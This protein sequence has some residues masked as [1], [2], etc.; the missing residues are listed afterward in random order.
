MLRLL[1]RVKIPTSCRRC[2]STKSTVMGFGDGSHGA[3]GLP[4]SIIGMGSD[5]YEPTPIPGLPPDVVSIAAGHFHSLAVTS[6][7]DVWSWGRNNEGQ[8][9]RHPLSLREAWNEPKRVEGLNKVRVQAAFASGVISAAVGDDGSLWVWG[10]S[11]H[12]QLGLGKGITHAALPSKIET[13]PGEEIVK[14]SLGWG[15]ALALAKNGSLFGWGYYADGRI[16]KIGRELEISPLESNSTKLRSGEEFS[17]IEA[18]EKSVMEAIEKE[19]D[20]PI[21][22]EPGSIE[23]LDELKVADVACGLDHSLVLCRDGTLLSGGSN[24]YGQL[25]RANKDLGMQPVDIELHPLSIA[26]GLGHS[27]A[28]CNDPSSEPTGDA[29]SVVSWGWNQSSQLGREGP[30]NIPNVVEGLAD[31]TPVSVS[32]GRAHSLAL[33]AKKEVWSW[34]SGRNGRL[35]LGSS[36]DEAE[37]MLVEY[38]EGTEVI[39]AVAGLDH[40]L[41]LV[42]E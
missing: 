1:H 7:G 32:A 8:L 34:G 29:T 36:A 15:H 3:L 38:L 30:D 2:M 5:A 11:K 28:V 16:G 23:E 21:I 39:Q 42:A 40:S 41:V 27:L 20:M 12:G 13:L 4:G 6:E 26:S 14:V 35:G 25:G 22:W 37:P 10:S 24:V 33:T 17:A 9:G 31:E 19:K 18:A